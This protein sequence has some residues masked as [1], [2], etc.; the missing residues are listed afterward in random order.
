MITGATGFIGSH[1][2][3]EL[4]QR[5][6]RVHL[7]TR[8]KN[9]RV[10]LAEKAG[11]MIHVGEMDDVDA[12]KNSIEE[13]DTVLHCAGATAAL[14]KN[15][16]LEANLRF[17]NNILGVIQK[18]QRFIYISSQAAA[19]PSTNNTPKKEEDPPEPLTYYG[20]SK[21]MAEKS[22][23]QWGK[24]HS[25]N[26]II[27][28]PSVVY[29]P[30]E[31]A[32]YQYFRFIHKGL[33]FVLGDGKILLSLIHVKDLVNAIIEAAEHPSQGE[34]FFVC[35]DTYHT[36]EEIGY[37]IQRALDKKH[38]VKIRLPLWLAYP[39]AYT[40]QT[41]SLITRKPALLDSQKMI[42]ARQSEWLCSNEKI[43]GRL[44]WRPEIPLETG[45]KETAR[46][47]VKEGWI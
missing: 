7:F 27:M 10:D 29:G 32:V 40:A 28:R 19:G 44:N 26:Y 47:Y 9:P 1:L 6:I 17:T 5:G 30:R 25:D 4:I 15:G 14:N 8:R 46:W 42:E 18:G 16:Y 11:A 39:C 38:L 23:R 2:A 41:L 3:E 22:V 13:V 12:L 20:T 24:L 36:W 43:K 21:L 31:K 35:G 34:T 37:T 45:I 33:L